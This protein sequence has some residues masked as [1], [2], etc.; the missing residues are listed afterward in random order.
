M[1]APHNPIRQWVSSTERHIA[2]S[3]EQV[4]NKNA[5]SIEIKKL[6]LHASPAIE[7]IVK[8]QPTSPAAKL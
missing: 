7:V 1:R 3:W 4:A 5:M 2:H 6:H 8:H